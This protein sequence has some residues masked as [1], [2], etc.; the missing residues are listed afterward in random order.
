MKCC[1]VG[2]NPCKPSP[3][4]NQATCRVYRGRVLCT[5]IY[6]FSGDGL[7]C[8]QI[9]KKNKAMFLVRVKFLKIFKLCWTQK[10]FFTHEIFYFITVFYKTR[11][12]SKKSLKKEPIRSTIKY[13]LNHCN[14]VTGKLKIIMNSGLKILHFSL[15]E[16]P[17]FWNL[18]SLDWN[19]VKNNYLLR[20]KQYF[21][22]L[23]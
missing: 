22:I 5:C 7:R 11:S 19:L 9:G 10:L 16:A 12:K 13:C 3:C 6:G 20:H 14:T 4:H 18:L 17:F 1:R 8:V 21:I 15:A 23:S 2:P